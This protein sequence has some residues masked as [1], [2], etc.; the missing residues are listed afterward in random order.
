MQY[1]TL[2]RCIIPKLNPALANEILLD[3]KPYFLIKMHKFMIA[4]VKLLE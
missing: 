2:V 1:P 4:A 3:F